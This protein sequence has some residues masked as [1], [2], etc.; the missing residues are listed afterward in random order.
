ME[1]CDFK[2]FETFSFYNEKTF[3]FLSTESLSTISSLVLTEHKYKMKK[4]VAFFFF[5]IM[6]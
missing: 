4:K 5:K 1:K 6:G 2:D 3:L